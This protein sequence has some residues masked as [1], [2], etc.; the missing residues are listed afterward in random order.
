MPRR[1]RARGPS[2][3]LAPARARR[4]ARTRRAKVG[5]HH[6]I[7]IAPPGLSCGRVARA[8]GR[9]SGPYA[10]LD[11]RESLDDLDERVVPFTAAAVLLQRVVELVNERGAGEGDVV[12]ERVVEDEA[13]ILLLQIDHEARPEVAGEH[14]RR[15]VVHRP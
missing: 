1:R 2:P 6:A 12:G 8:R 9:T 14:L 7:A 4:T 15:V 13:E 3:P 5:R 10:R 11:L